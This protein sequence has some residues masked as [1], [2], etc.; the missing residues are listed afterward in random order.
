[1]VSRIKYFLAYDSVTVLGLVDGA[2]GTPLGEDTARRRFIGGGRGL[3]LRRVD[4]AKGTP[5]QIGVKSTCKTGNAK[6]TRRTGLA[7]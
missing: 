2:L 3:R 6:T 7:F 5:N 1:M 4:G